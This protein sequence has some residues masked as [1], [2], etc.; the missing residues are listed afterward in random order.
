MKVGCNDR[1]LGG[2]SGPVK[3]QFYFKCKF[4]PGGTFSLAYLRFILH[5]YPL[6]L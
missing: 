5:Q 2:V 3:E 1:A 4:K 6:P